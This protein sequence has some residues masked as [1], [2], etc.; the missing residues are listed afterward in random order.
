MCTENADRLD[1]EEESLNGGH[2]GRA[3]ISSFEPVGSLLK[4]KSRV[5]AENAS[6]R[7]QLRVLQREVRGRVEF[8][9]SDRLFLVLLY[10]WFPSVL[11]SMMSIECRLWGSPRIH[12][13][14]RQGGSPGYMTAPICQ[15]TNSAPP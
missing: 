12:G 9:N 14:I 5:G 2:D 10:R 13:G 1:L 6:L 8:T 7:H 4:S 11:K 3:D 15:G